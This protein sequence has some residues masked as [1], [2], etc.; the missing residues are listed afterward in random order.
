[1]RKIAAPMTFQT[2]QVIS[3]LQSAAQTGFERLARNVSSALE[4]DLRRLIFDQECK[5]TH[6]D[7]ETLHAELMMVASMPDQDH[8]AFMTATIV[9]LSDRLHYGA[10]EDDLFWNWDA[11]QERF[12]EAPSPVRAALMNGFRCADARGLVK[13]DQAPK[14][15][16]L[17]TY[18]EEDL[19]R[20]LKIIARSMTEEMRDRVAELAPEEIREVHRKALDN[21]LRASC[22]LSEFGGWFPTEV[23][24]Q[25]SLDPL[26][27]SY[28]ACTALMILDAI[29]TRDAQGKMAERYEEHADSYIL[30]P[31]QIRVPLMAGLRHLHEM[32]TD[33]EPYA[34][35]PADKRLDKAI[36][37]PFA[38]P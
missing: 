14:G 37:M 13:L 20:L 25:V 29:E 23:V 24:E 21:C 3:D 30:L 33:W 35:W 17:R 10:G 6:N 1:M 8:A 32:E 38:K 16:D 28:A 26:H 2:M 36:V 4:A 11:F 27:E 7:L 31:T 5:M 19:V 18:D 9:L 12:R 15:T 22:V 34:T